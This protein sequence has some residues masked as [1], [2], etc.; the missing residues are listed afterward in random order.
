MSKIE[1]T[2]PDNSKKK[3]ESGITPQ[4]IAEDISQ[5]LAKQ[6]I[7]A[8]VNGKLVDLNHPLNQDAKIVLYK[9]NSAEGREVYWHSTAHLMAQAVKELFPDVKVTIGP[10]IETGFYYDFDKEVPFTDADL[11]KIENKMIELSKENLEYHRQELPKKEAEQIFRKMGEDYKLEI[12]DE[13]PDSETISVYKQGNFIDLCRGPHILH[14]GKIK[15]IKLLK[16]SGAYWRGDSNNKMLQRIYGVSFPSKKELRKYLHNLEEAKK[17]DHRKI[18]KE[19]DIYSIQ[20]EIGPGLVLWHPNGAMMRSIIEDFWKKRHFQENYQLVNTPH[21]GKAG[22]WETSGHLSFYHDSMYAPM[23]IDE[24]EYYIKPMN[25]PFHIAIYQNEKRSYR[26]LPIKYAEMGTVYRYEPSGALHGL[27]RVRG[28]TQDDAHIICTPEQLDEEVE[29][30]IEFSLEMLRA[31]G[32]EDFEIFLSTRPE[33]AVGIPEK[34]EKAQLSLKKALDK[35]GIEYA[36]DEGGGAFYGPKIDIKIKDALNR[37]WQCSTIQFDFNLPERF[38]MEYIGADNNSHQPYMIHRALLGSM[39]R[40]FG[41]LIEYHAGNFPLWLCPVQVKVIPISE[42]FEK[43]ARQV[44]KELKQHDIRSEIDHKNEKV[45]YKIRE[46]EIKK[47]P[48]MLIVGEKEENSN[49]V[50]VR[51]HTVGNQGTS[52]LTDF[53]SELQKEIKSKK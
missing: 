53:I 36:M 23:E 16:T 34:W 7:T 51:K 42:N 1:I 46:A 25:C 19:L 41:T 44:E 31:F 39:E 30:T 13:I 3:Y 43:Y 10:A 12:L 47:I 22:L 32:F 2:F 17:R 5:G 50:S 45:G 11:E 6:I 28:F 20:D 35:L 49:T 37:S 48:Y 8:R 18:G 9:F 26:E 24:Q 29:N 38:N 27:M 33:K 40:F 21:I 52:S 14:T 15:A 4:K